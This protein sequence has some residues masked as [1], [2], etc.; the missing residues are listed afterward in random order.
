M[1]S[2]D[3]LV[4]GNDGI[5]PAHNFLGTTDNQP[6]TIK[7]NGAE[8]VRVDTNGNVGIG[9]DTPEFILDVNK[10]IRLRGEEPANTAGLWLFQASKN[11]AF[12]GMANDAHVGLFGNNGANWGLVMDTANGN[13]GIGGTGRSPVSKLHVDV[14]ASPNPIGALTIEVESFKTAENA[15]ASHFLSVEGPLLVPVVRPPP[16]GS[17]PAVPGPP[18][19]VPIGVTTYFRIRGDGNVGIGTSHTS[20]IALKRIPPKRKK[21]SADH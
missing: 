4:T 8:R 13:V 2:T 17:G 14:A 9:T 19:L 18:D 7:T 3:W 16:L 20:R 5:D 11:Q 21:N 15:Q 1:S 12:V 6:L 10:R